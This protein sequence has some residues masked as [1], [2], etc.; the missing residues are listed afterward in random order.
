MSFVDRNMIYAIVAVLFGSSFLSILAYYLS[1][2]QHKYNSSIVSI[3]YIVFIMGLLGVFAYHKLKCKKITI[4]SFL[5]FLNI[6]LKFTG[7]WI[8]YILYL[9][10]FKK[11]IKWYM[12]IFFIFLQAYVNI[13]VMPDVNI[14]MENISKNLKCKG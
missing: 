14:Q 2:M 12:I 13:T 6:I 8:L 9:E 3:L 7:I 1:K 10:Y 5:I 4:Q 11:E